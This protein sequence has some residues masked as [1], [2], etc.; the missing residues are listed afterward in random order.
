MTERRRDM[1]RSPLSRPYERCRLYTE[2]ESE[3]A[4]LFFKQTA[5]GRLVCIRFQ[6]KTFAVSGA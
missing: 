2:L 1:T 4:G 5:D 3:T 6:Q